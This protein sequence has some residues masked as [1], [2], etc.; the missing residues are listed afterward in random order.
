ME[1]LSVPGFSS[2]QVVHKAE[3]PQPNPFV[4]RG[5]P[6][7][8]SYQMDR[9]V[10]VPRDPQIAFCYWEITGSLLG[11]VKK[12]KGDGFVNSATWVL[13]TYKRSQSLAIDAAID[14][15]AGSWYVHVGG[16][17]EY[18]FVLALL[19]SNG[20][21]L[22]LLASEVFCSP[23]YGLSDE[24]DEEWFSIEEKGS[25][26]PMEDLSMGFF[27][28]GSSGHLGMGLMQEQ[29][30]GGASG[31]VPSSPGKWSAGAGSGQFLGASKVP[32]QRP[33]RPAS[34]LNVQ[35]NLPKANEDDR[36]LPRMVKVETYP[37]PGVLFQL[38]V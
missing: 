22:P 4:D 25:S 33:G 24:M 9:L 27:P 2:G 26:L 5:L 32:S 1:I 38:A 19:S 11:L 37:E 34:I 21:F 36:W 16:P 3:E 28:L 8:D 29:Q 15:H 35:E 13:R 31:L 20:E 6:L 12:A 10:G 7:P 17:G 23:G 30:L 14:P 18:Q